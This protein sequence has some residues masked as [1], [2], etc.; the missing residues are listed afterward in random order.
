M[1]LYINVALG[2]LG[3]FTP[4]GFGVLK[5]HTSLALVLLH[6]T[7]IV[8]ES[9]LHTTHMH[10]HTHTVSNVML[11]APPTYLCIAEILCGIKFCWLY[12][13]THGKNKTYPREAGRQRRNFSPRKSF[14]AI[15]MR[16]GYGYTVQPRLSE[17][18][19]PAPKSKGSDKHK[20][21][22]NYTRSTV[23]SAYSH[24]LPHIS[25]TDLLFHS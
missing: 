1:R 25:C 22:D 20:C 17:P 19:W 18:I 16:Y 3:H 8:C 4:S 11:S 10:T 24:K 2:P 13:I 7:H 6:W 23:N 14:L 9:V 21:L 15:N 5:C 12:V